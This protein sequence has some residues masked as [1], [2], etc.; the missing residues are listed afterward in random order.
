MKRGWYNLGSH[1]LSA[2]VFPL[3]W[4]ALFLYAVAKMDGP[5]LEQIEQEAADHNEDCNC[6]KGSLLY[7]RQA[8]VK[9]YV[10][11]N[12]SSVVAQALTNNSYIESSE[13]AAV[14]F[15]ERSHRF[16]NVGGALT[17]FLTL[18][19]SS[20]ILLINYI[21]LY[22]QNF[23]VFPSKISS[24]SLQLL[25]AVSLGLGIS[26]LISGLLGTSVDALLFCFLMEKKGE[27]M[28]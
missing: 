19:T 6:L 7:L 26:T 13:L 11:M 23:G 1:A 5:T 16:F 10:K 28:S 22:Y 8:L 4:I 24:L 25:L 20:L 12:R 14:T 3:E 2:I 15:S 18:F 17:I 21:P 27:S 9:L